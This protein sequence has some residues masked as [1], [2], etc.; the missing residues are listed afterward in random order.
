MEQEHQ[1]EKSKYISS[2]KDPSPCVDEGIPGSAH[3][4]ATCECG[5]NNLNVD[6]SDSTHSSLNAYR[7]ENSPC[8]EDYNMTYFSPSAGE[9]NNACPPTKC[10]S[11]DAVDA[12]NRNDTADHSCSSLI[13]EKANRNASLKN[14][15]SSGIASERGVRSGIDGDE[16]V[17]NITRDVMETENI[18]VTDKSLIS[19]RHVEGVRDITENPEG[20]EN[21]YPKAS[22]L[23]TEGHLKAVTNS[24]KDLE[25][26]KDVCFI[27]GTHNNDGQHSEER[28]KLHEAG[29][30]S[31]TSWHHGESANDHQSRDEESESACSNMALCEM[32]AVHKN[33]TQFEQQDLLVPWHLKKKSSRDAKSDDEKSA[34]KD[35]QVFFR[36]YHVFVEGEMEELCQ[37]LGDVSVTNTYYDQ[38]NWC[39]VF[40][41]L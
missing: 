28:P 16:N 39:V 14:G 7:T 22:S 4:S 17:T 12:W 41:K 5:E 24:R 34:S 27:D 15:G 10:G 35:K 25:G 19:E 36:Y 38:G 2:K 13:S 8:Y 26:R 23:I 31:D 40:K 33:R 11:T 9:R 37:T 18:L 6:S 1:Q 20:V 32:I 30:K 21:V 29:D 3:H